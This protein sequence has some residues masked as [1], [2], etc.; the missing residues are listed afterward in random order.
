MTA[1]TNSEKPPKRRHTDRRAT[2]EWGW[3]TGLDLQIAWNSPRPQSRSA[4]KPKS[5]GEHFCRPHR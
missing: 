4:R 2:R 1:T 3:T 5:A